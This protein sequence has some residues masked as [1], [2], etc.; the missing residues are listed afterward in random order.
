MEANPEIFI[1]CPHISDC[2]EGKGI[3]DETFFTRI[4]G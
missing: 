2:E 1:T 4:L 3:V